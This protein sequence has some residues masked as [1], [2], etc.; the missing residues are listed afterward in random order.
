MTKID[1]WAFYGSTIS[2]IT[3]PSN[4][5]TIG[6]SAFYACINLT[7][8][9]IPASVQYINQMAFQGCS[10]I[11]SVEFKNITG[12]KAYSSTSYTNGEEIAL[13]ATDFYTNATKLL[14]VYKDKYW[15]RG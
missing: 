7:S 6:A 9:V 3:L 10:S 13:S 5:T 11:K 4:L 12:W 1:E 14:S 2:S 15:K 8:I